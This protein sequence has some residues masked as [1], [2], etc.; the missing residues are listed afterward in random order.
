MLSSLTLAVLLLNTP[1]STHPS[2]LCSAV[3]PAGLRVNCSSLGLMDLPRLPPDTAELH[4]QRNRLTSVAPGLF[5]RFVSLKKVSLSENPFHCDCGIRY[6][7][8]WLLRNRAIVPQQPVCASPDSVA[9]TP[10]ADLEDGYFSS[11]G[12][13][14]C[15]DGTTYG[16]VVGL[17]L[18]CVILLL[19][20]SVR[21]A[22]R[23]T[24]TLYI[25]QRHWGLEAESLRPL[26]PKHRRRM[27]S[28]RSHL[29]S[30]LDS[31]GSPQDLERPLLNME[32]LPQV[33]DVLHKKH[34]IK[35]KAT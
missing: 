5:D 29:S 8:N 18:C 12:G 7:R 4:L 28:G 15:S 35:I 25:E 31:L 16:L 26:R 14:R 9:L 34:N 6:L 19:L 24:F 2:C 3:R 23:S 22:R 20:W 17:M 10:I 21:L 33:L 27:N 30:D 1:V 11:C 13:A 32:I